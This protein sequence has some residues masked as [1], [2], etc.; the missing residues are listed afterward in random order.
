MKGKNTPNNNQPRNP[1]SYK[2]LEFQTAITSTKLSY[3]R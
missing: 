2:L 1:V 3:P